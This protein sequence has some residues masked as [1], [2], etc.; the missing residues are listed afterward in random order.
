[1]HK[2]VN[3]ALL[4]ITD[5]FANKQ[6]SYFES[7]CHTESIYHQCMKKV[8]QAFWMITGLITNKHSSY[9][10]NEQ[11][12]AYGDHNTCNKPMLENLH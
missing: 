10:K 5:L 2:K 12:T 11:H 3:Q 4:V 1:M 7:E 9:S 6:S 8:K